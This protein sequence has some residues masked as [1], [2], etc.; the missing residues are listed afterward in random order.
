[1][2]LPAAVNP[3]LSKILDDFEKSP[4]VRVRN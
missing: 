1:V 3:F 4:D 2:S